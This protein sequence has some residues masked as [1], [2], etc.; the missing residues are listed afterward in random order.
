MARDP[1]A[2]RRRNRIDTEKQA[3]SVD[4]RAKAK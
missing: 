2:N 4:A 3:E 1:V